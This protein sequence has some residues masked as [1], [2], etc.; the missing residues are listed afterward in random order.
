MSSVN[1]GDNLAVA[2]CPFPVR[3]AGVRRYTNF[4]QLVLNEGLRN[5]LPG[6]AT[7]ADGVKVMQGSLPDAEVEEKGVLALVLEKARG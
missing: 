2:T 4:R 5:V 7:V 1:A 3:V 6:V